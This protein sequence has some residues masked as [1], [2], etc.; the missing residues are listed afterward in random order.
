MKQFIKGAIAHVFCHYAEEF[1]L[2]AYT[3][4]LDYVVK[5]GLVKNL[6]FFQ[7]TISLSVRNSKHSHTGYKLIKG[8]HY[9]T[10]EKIFHCAQK[11]C[12]SRFVCKQPT[13]RPVF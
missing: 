1:R 5:S 12:I 8:P 11:T 9:A 10:Q 2:I 7:Q 3:K 13:N 6:C 4:N